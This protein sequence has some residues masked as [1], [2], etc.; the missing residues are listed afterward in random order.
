MLCKWRELRYAID[1]YP[2]MGY[3]K[4]RKRGFMSRTAMIR[5]RTEPKVKLAAEKIFKQLGIS[6]SAAINMFYQQVV[7]EKGLPFALR[8]PNV[9]SMQAIQQMKAGK[10]TRYKSSKAM[11][12]D[13]LGKGWDK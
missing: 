10:G 11:F 6:A 1:M 4:G 8:V 13:I 5:V 2:I 7:V 9:S 3:N 12:D